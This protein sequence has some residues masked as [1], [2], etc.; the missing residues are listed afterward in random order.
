MTR[1]DTFDDDFW[2]ATCQTCDRPRW[3][4]SSFCSAIHMSG[5][6]WRLGAY[7]ALKDIAKL[8]MGCGSIEHTQA[9]ALARKRTQLN[10]VYEK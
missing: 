6:Y 2:A 7:E 8:P 1:L 4:Q 5:H 10:E 9:I 3:H